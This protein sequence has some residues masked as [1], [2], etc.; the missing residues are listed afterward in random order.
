MRKGWRGEKELSSESGDCDW[1]GREREETPEQRNRLP[2]SNVATSI[3]EKFLK[4]RKGGRGNGDG[5][6]KLKSGGMEAKAIALRKASEGNNIAWRGSDPS[7]IDSTL[8][9]Q[10]V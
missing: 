8:N 7:D 2:R 3:W 4:G 5:G 6:K 9:Y 10:K 1:G